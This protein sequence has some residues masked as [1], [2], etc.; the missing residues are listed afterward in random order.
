MLREAGVQMRD[1]VQAIDALGELE[2][3]VFVSAINF[4]ARYDFSCSAILLSLINT[5]SYSDNIHT[6]ILIL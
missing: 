2:N 4:Y 6:H 5:K 3:S 1:V